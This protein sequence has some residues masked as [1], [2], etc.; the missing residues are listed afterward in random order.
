MM[1]LLSIITTGTLSCALSLSA[2]VIFN[3]TFED[4]LSIDAWNPVAS[5]TNDNKTWLETGGNPGG[6][7]EIAG[8]SDGP[9]LNFAFQNPLPGTDFMGM[10]SLVIEFD[11][12][13]SQPLVGGVFHL[14]TNTMG[15][16]GASNAVNFFNLENQLTADFTTIQLDV[17]GVPANADTLF[18][19]FNLVTGAFDGS[20]GGVTI[21]NITVT[22]IPE[23]SVYAALLGLLALGLVAAR[24]RAKRS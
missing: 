24:R 9:G 8:F 4:A 20:G 17:S 18:L 23:P 1:K 14:L 10:D 13:I 3:E 6:A 21:D 19:E 7:M 15:P 5:A 22:A 16:G 2:S 12:R 11:A